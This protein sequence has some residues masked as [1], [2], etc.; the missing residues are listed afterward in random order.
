MLHAH[1]TDVA[2]TWCREGAW[3]RR[4]RRDASTSGRKLGSS[5]P[6]T[7]EEQRS[8]THLGNAMVSQCMK[9]RF[10]FSARYRA[11]PDISIPCIALDGARNLMKTCTRLNAFLSAP[12]RVETTLAH[13]EV[14]EKSHEHGTATRRLPETPL[15]ASALQEQCD[16]YIWRIA[17]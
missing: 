12:D 8:K 9:A 1:N 5:L 7:F 4:V 11:T 17:L 6:T 15:D 3:R 13:L 14:D 2:R 10:R 16:P